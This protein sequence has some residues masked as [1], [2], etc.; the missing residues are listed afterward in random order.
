MGD[1]QLDQARD[2]GWD[3]VNSLV[4]RRAGCVAGM[5]EFIATMQRHP[6][7]DWKS[8]AVIDW[9]QDLAPA[10]AWFCEATA[11]ARP[12]RAI[13]GL[14]FSVPQIELGGTEVS[15]LG[16][17]KF[18]A[19]GKSLEWAVGLTWPSNE[20]NEI[21]TTGL[22]CVKDAATRLGFSE[23][24]NE[25]ATGANEILTYLLPLVYCGLLLGEILDA[26]PKTRFPVPGGIG[27]SVGFVDGDWLV[28]RKP[29]P[30]RRRG[31]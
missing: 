9:S 3:L 21:T 25:D 2:L 10:T 5:L 13:R 31:K 27:A 16:A 11:K 20:Q 12:T 22:I 29:R 23:D 4:K 7:G 17:R 24:Y 6:G 19:T 18:D 28:I 15:W 14:W 8:L 1:E 30:I 26:L